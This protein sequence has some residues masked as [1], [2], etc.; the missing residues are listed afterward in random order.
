VGEAHTKAS[1]ESVIDRYG[2]GETPVAAA[3]RGLGHPGPPGS[4]SPSP[5]PV[6]HGVRSCT[7]DASISRTLPAQ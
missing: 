3:Q 6:L 4:L 5:L 7:S 2:K 1:P